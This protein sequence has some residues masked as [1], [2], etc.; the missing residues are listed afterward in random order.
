MEVH[1]HAHTRRKKWTHYFWEF[2]MLFLAV[3]CGFLAEIQ[4]E[5]K[6]ERDRAKILANNLYQET[7]ADSV[8]V[9]KAIVNRN[10]KEKESQ[11]FIAY[12]KDS[13][14]V[15]LSPHFFKAFS[16]SLLNTTMVLFEPNDGI[17]NQLRNSGELRYFKNADLQSA[18]SS[19]S[20]K[21]AHL[22]TR[23]EREYGYVEAHN[24]PFL[25]KHFDYR[26]YEEFTKNGALT[27]S[28]ALKQNP[29]VSQPAK[30]V[31]LSS[32][33]RQEAESIASYY[34]LMLRSTRQVQYKEYAEANHKLLEALR[35]QYKI[36]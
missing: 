31:N 36:K 22:R 9:S 7:Y 2:L 30:L 27:L 24:R 25:L 14:L 19:L 10:M 35:K 13:N 20:V 21:I 28:E 8:A 12:V 17:L 16:T 32:F 6:I 33:N 11:Y 29:P 5:H 23:N 34:Q 3:F 18:I 26:W 1:H 4:L 15:T